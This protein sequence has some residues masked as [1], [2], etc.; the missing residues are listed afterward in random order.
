[1]LSCVILILFTKSMSVCVRVCVRENV[2]FNV[3]VIVIY[4]K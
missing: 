4:T 2:L 3:F 1:M